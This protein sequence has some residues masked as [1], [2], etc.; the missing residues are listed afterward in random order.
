MTNKALSTNGLLA[1]LI[2][3]IRGFQVYDI[4]L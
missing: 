3:Y 1:D 4:F 2:R